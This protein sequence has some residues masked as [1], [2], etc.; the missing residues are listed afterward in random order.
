MDFRQVERLPTVGPENLL[1][2]TETRRNNEAASSGVC[3]NRGQTNSF[4]DG[5]GYAYCSFSKKKARHSAAS[6]V[7]G[8]Q[9][10]GPSFVARYSSPSF[11]ID[12]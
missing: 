1:L 8:L 4:A 2:Q 11:I 12:L 7:D 5:L 10:G 3:G 9:I 6:G